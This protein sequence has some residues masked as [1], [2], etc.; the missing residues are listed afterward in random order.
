MHPLLF[1]YPISVDIHSFIHLF[2]ANEHMK[3]VSKLIALQSLKLFSLAFERE[4]T[5]LKN[6]SNESC[7]KYYILNS[8]LYFKLFVKKTD[9]F[10][11]EFYVNYE[12]H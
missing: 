4:F 9:T 10:R 1:P 7:W 12:L 5:M 8:F 3:I 6:V 2:I 11:F